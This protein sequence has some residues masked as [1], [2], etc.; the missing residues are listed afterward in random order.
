MHRFAHRGGG[1]VCRGRCRSGLGLKAELERLGGERAMQGVGQLGDDERGGRL[2]EAAAEL[3]VFEMRQGNVG[4]PVLL[5]AE[6]E[7][8]IEAAAGEMKADVAESKFAAG[9]A[10]GAPALLGAGGGVES[11]LIPA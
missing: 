6:V 4:D 5:R 8:F 1:L 7:L 9:G 11:F 10:D 3:D 2:F